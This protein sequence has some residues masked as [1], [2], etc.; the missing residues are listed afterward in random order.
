MKNKTI[1]LIMFASLGITFMGTWTI[2]GWFTGRQFTSPNGQWALLRTVQKLGIR[3][4]SGLVKVFGTG[5]NC[6]FGYDGPW[7]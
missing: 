1:L 3:L 2:T 5:T 4:G 7:L 6:I